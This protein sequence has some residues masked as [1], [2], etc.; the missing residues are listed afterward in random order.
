[1]LINRRRIATGSFGQ[2]YVGSAGEGGPHPS[3]RAI[4]GR[5]AARE[6]K[7]AVAKLVEERRCIQRVAVHGAFVT[8]E[9]FADH[10]YHIGAR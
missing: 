8:A 4:S 9:R 7:T 1:M 10:E 6:E 2:C 5:E 3:C